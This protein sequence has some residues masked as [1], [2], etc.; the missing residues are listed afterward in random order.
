MKASGPSELCLPA[1]KVCFMQSPKGLGV[2]LAILSA[3]CRLRAALNDAR[4]ATLGS[5]ATMIGIVEIA[6]GGIVKPE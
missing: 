4:P 6:L 5:D 1:L 2:W 3:M